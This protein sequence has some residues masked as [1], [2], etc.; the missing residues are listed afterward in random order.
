MLV[1]RMRLKMLYYILIGIILAS[2]ILLM[3]MLN[4]SA[5]TQTES[6]D[7]TSSHP[8]FAT[9]DSN[10][11]SNAA[12][13][14]TAVGS[15]P[16]GG[17]QLLLSRQGFPGEVTVSIREWG[18]NGPVGEDL[19]SGTTDGNSLPDY[20]SGGPSSAEWRRIN[21]DSILNVTHNTK[22]FIVIKGTN[23]E[24]HFVSWWRNNI[25]DGWGY[26]GGNPSYKLSFSWINQGYD[27]FFRVF[28][29]N[30]I[31]GPDSIT[32]TSE[33]YSIAADGISTTI[34]VANVVDCHGDPVEDGLWV[35]FTTNNGTI[36]GSDT[37]LNGI[38]PRLL[39]SEPSS[40]IVVATIIATIDS[41]S[42]AIAVF[43]VPEGGKDVTDSQTEI[44]NGSGT[45]S[46]TLTGG[47]ININ[48]SGEHIITVAEYQGN[49]KKETVFRVT[50]DF[51]DVHLNDSSNVNEV[52][53]RFCPATPQTKIFYWDGLGWEIASNQIYDSGC[54]IVTVNNSTQPNLSDL[55]GLILVP[56][57]DTVD[58]GIDIKPGKVPNSINLRSKGVVPVAIIT[59]PEFDASSVDPDTVSF[60]G[61]QSVHWALKD[62][63]KDG[64]LDMILHFRTQ[65]LNLSET[66]LEAELTG[67]TTGSISIIGTD[68]VNI[69]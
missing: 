23:P 10:R 61:A 13:S 27:L 55:S 41:I 59:S 24:G 7:S 5:D 9:M 52:I 62:V 2:L 63:D 40:D 45:M 48:A 56:G 32:L 30:S 14:F 50:G 46:N 43:F 1:K 25:L 3:P 44:I 35:D 42:D 38:A 31:P 64:D 17:V 57:I 16:V 36:F 19:V 15:H 22:Y 60:A 51:Y 4:L 11:D 26:L 47:A 53:I 21:F 12:Q 6:Y 37:T 34:L 58:V 49:P 18:L 20:Y 28:D 67:E 66:S 29:D 65:E 68:S 8:P 69:I 39:E 54:I 33:D